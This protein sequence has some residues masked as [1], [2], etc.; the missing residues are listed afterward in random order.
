M[1]IVELH[2]PTRTEPR[3]VRV[4]DNVGTILVR[5]DSP[6]PSR[7]SR[8]APSRSHPSRRDERPIMILASGH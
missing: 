5:N 2:D 1:L 3:I 6:R 8:R 4:D 7:V